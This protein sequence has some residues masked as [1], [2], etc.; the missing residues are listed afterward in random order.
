[1]TKFIRE[2]FNYP[3]TS[4]KNNEHGTIYAQFVVNSDGSISDLKVIKGVSPALDNEVIRV[5]KAMPNWI[6]GMVNG[7]NVNVRYV[8]PVK[9]ILSDTNEKTK[10]KKQKRKQKRKHKRD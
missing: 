5:I 7:E 1:M 2:N 4:M 8:V 9:C 6:P 3:K 10:S